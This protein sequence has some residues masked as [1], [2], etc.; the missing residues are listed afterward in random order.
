MRLEN[1]QRL[2]PLPSLL[3]MQEDEIL[4]QLDHEYMEELL[5]QEEEKREVEHKGLNRVQ[6]GDTKVVDNY[7]SMGVGI[8]KKEQTIASSADKERAVAEPSAESTIKSK[9]IKKRSKRNAAAATE[10]LSLRI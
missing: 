6:T 9:A 5:L 1:P 4:K 8:A 7:R 10:Q 3:A 2:Y